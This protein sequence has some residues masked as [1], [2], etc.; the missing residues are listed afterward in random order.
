MPQTSNSTLSYTKSMVAR[1]TNSNQG[2]TV[3]DGHLKLWDCQPHTMGM[4]PQNMP[5]TSNSLLSTTKLMVAKGNQ[6]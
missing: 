2:Q 5:Q 6:S 4:R 1:P 3:S